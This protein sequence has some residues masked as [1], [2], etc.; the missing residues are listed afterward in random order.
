MWKMIWVMAGGAAGTLL[1]Y[2]VSGFI[3]GHSS[4][5]F[6]WGTFAVNISGSFLIGLL[7]GLS[8]WW[9][10]SH[11]LKLFLFIGLFGGFT[12]FS[13]FALESL[14]LLKSGEVKAALFNIGLSNIAGL[15]MVYLGY[16][17]AKS[18]TLYK[19]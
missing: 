5:V 19:L 8:G 12:T 10:Y 13:T 14:N 17:L 15:V 3:Q 16:L 7:W 2:S 4:S 11:S 1:R 18:I 9:N 6:P